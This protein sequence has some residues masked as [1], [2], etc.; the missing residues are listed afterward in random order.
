MAFRVLGVDHFVHHRRGE[1]PLG[2]EVKPGQKGN[3]L[4]R[5]RQDDGEG[6]TRVKHIKHHCQRRGQICQ[7][8]DNEK[9]HCRGKSSHPQ[10]PEPDGRV[11]QGALT[12]RK[13]PQGQE[14][15]DHKQNRGETLNP[16]LQ[17]R[18]VQC[19]DELDGERPGQQCGHPSGVALR[20]GRRDV[21][22]FDH[23]ETDGDDQQSDPAQQPQIQMQ[24]F[25]RREISPLHP[26]SQQ[27][28]HPSAYSN[29]QEEIVEGKT[30]P[31]G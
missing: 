28:E 27:R 12:H 1:I 13:T 11:G 10:A 4:V 18:S 5:H 22:H 7:I 3:D 15:V 9:K 31:P 14:R 8:S 6:E 25:Q 16:G 26:A 19:S 21:E 24:L 2:V 20:I 29:E 17:H 30:H 23:L